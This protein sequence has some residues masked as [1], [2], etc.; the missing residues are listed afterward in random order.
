MSF[1]SILLGFCLFLFSILVSLYLLA[2][3][4]LDLNE[5][6]HKPKIKIETRAKE[7]IPVTTTK[8]RFKKPAN[9]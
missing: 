8:L 4:Y 9:L 1:D 7:L 2:I 6:I 3:V 5:P